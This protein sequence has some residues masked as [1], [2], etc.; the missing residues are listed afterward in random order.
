MARINKHKDPGPY[1]VAI[2]V[3]KKE[4]WKYDTYTGKPMYMPKQIP[5]PIERYCEKCGKKARVQPQGVGFYSFLC[6]ECSDE[7]YK[8]MHEQYPDIYPYTKKTLEST[9]DIPVKIGDELIAP[10]PDLT[11]TIPPEPICKY[12]E[13]RFLRKRCGDHFTDICKSCVHN[14]KSKEG[15]SYHLNHPKKP[16]SYYDSIGASCR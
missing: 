8:H 1:T 4:V 2:P 6:G 11:M 16:K 13:N 15:E 12:T 9:G 5:K 3:K 7:F 10:D 14:Y